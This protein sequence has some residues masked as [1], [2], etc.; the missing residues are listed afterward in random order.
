[1]GRSLCGYVGEEIAFE[2]VVIWVRRWSRGTQEGGVVHLRG[3]V[4]WFLVVLRETE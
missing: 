3:L 4:L 1:V 2:T